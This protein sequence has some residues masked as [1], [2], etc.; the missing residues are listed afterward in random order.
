MADSFSGTVIT[1]SIPAINSL[2]ERSRTTTLCLGGELYRPTRAMVGSDAIKAALG[3]RADIFFLGA[4]SIDERGVYANGDVERDIKRALIDVS[5]L[6]VLM[7]DQQ[8]LSSSAPVCICN[9]DKIDTLLTDGEP[10][11]SLRRKLEAEN[12]K[13]IVV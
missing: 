13:T 7:V 5:D 4:S 3:L 9:W 1:H 11:A 8:K 6:T 12:V 2:Q 10:P